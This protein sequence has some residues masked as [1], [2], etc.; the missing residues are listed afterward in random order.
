MASKYENVYAKRAKSKLIDP[1][2]RLINKE[3]IN[4]EY[5]TYF[6]RVDILHQLNPKELGEAPKG[7]L[8]VVTAFKFDEEITLIRVTN[9]GCPG[10]EKD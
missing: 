3:T 9:W 4:E 1:S 5:P 8:D 10:S 7:D 6:L 2:L